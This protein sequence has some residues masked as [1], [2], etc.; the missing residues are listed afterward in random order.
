MSRLGQAE[1]GGYVLAGGKSSRMGR[2]KALLEINGL[3]LIAQAVAKLRVVCA[4]V[5]I[6]GNKPE[7]AAY[8]QLVPDLHADCGP[9][10]GVEAALD[11]SRFDWNLLVPVD[12]PFLPAEF[13]REWAERVIR[14]EALRLGY[15]EAGGRPQPGVLLIHRQTRPQ[16]SAA[17]ERGDYKLL[18]ALTAAANGRR[19][20]ERIDGEHESWFANVNTPEDLE[21]VRHRKEKLRDLAAAEPKRF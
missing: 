15:F 13:L 21:S 16:V 5:C 18:P 3:P 14:D 10:G 19:H 9:I 1:I 20:V 7:L 2:D 8:G 4:E 6:L 17:I 11:H 12:V